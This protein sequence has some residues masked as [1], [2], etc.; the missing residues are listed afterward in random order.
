MEARRSAAFGVNAARLERV[1]TLILYGG[2]PLR[3]FRCE[4]GIRCRGDD[5]LF[6]CV[7][8]LRDHIFVTLKI[9]TKK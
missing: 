4:R 5:A 3:R 8:Y 7:F 1:Y 6:G 9:F 2:A